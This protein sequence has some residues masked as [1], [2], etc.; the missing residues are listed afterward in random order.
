MPKLRESKDASL[1]KLIT[2]T[3]KKYIVLRDVQH[4]ELAA[5]LNMSRTTLS[6]RLNSDVE[7]FSI[8]GEPIVREFNIVY[9]KHTDVQEKIDLFFA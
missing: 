5:R 2:A 6:R 1:N 9:L 7:K 3:I 8:Q 4:E